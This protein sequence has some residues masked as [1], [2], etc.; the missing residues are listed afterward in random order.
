MKASQVK[1]LLGWILAITILNFVVVVIVMINL[2]SVKMQ[3]K[4]LNGGSSDKTQ[5]SSI[6]SSVDGLTTTVNQ[7]KPAIATVPTTTTLGKETTCTGTLSLN[8][9]GSIL[10]NYANFSSITP[11]NLTCNPL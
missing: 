3:V 9:S 10:N 2:G 5:L 11:V 7:L 4:N 6:Q 8:L 1:L